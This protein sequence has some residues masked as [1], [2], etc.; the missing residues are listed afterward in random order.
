MFYSIA[1]FGLMMFFGVLLMMR[2]ITLSATMASLLFMYALYSFHMGAALDLSHEW[3]GV[4]VRLV[5]G[6][7]G[8]ASFVLAGIVFVLRSRE[9]DAI[10]ARTSI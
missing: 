8:I 6:C 9:L 4:V 10:R 3:R 5:F 1:M 2:R 7:V